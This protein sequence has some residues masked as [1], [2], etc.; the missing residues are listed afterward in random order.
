LVLLAAEEFDSL[1]ETAHLLKS[2]ANAARLLE[3]FASA[4]QNKTKAMKIE[5]FRAALGF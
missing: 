3:A 4:R 1:A 2:P 5:D